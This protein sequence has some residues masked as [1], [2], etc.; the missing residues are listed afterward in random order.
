MTLQLV[1]LEICGVHLQLVMSFMNE[2]FPNGD[3]KKKVQQ[4]E[5]LSYEYVRVEKAV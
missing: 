1:C 2:E 3:K 5:K 4:Y